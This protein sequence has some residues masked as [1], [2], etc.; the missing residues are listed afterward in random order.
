VR[1]LIEQCSS[2]AKESRE[3]LRI[4]AEKVKEARVA[5]AA[6]LV[7]IGSDIK[8]TGSGSTFSQSGTNTPSIPG[9]STPS[10]SDGEFNNILDPRAKRAIDKRKK[11]KLA[12][13]NSAS[14]LS[15]SSSI[16]SSSIPISGNEFT[17][18]IIEIYEE[19]IRRA[20]EGCVEGEVFKNSFS[21]EARKFLKLDEK[22]LKPCIKFVF[23]NGATYER[24]VGEEGVCKFVYPDKSVYEGH[25]LAGLPNGL[26]MRMFPDGSVY[27]GYFF[28]ELPHGLGKYVLKNKDMLE[29]NFVNGGI[30]G[31]CK[32]T[33]S[34][35]KYVCE[36]DFPYSAKNTNW[37]NRV[38]LSDGSVYEGSFVN[39]QANGQGRH[40]L[41]DGSVY[42]GSFVNGRANGQGKYT[43]PDGSVYEGFFVNE[44][45]IGQGKYTL[46]DGSACEGF[47]LNG[48]IQ[49]QGKYTFPDGNAYEGLLLNG[50]PI[51]QGK[52]TFK[53]GDELIGIFVGGK[54]NGKGGYVFSTGEYYVGEFCYGRILNNTKGVL[55]IDESGIAVCR[56]V[57][58]KVLG[59]GVIEFESEDGWK[60][61]MKVLEDGWKMKVLEDGEVKDKGTAKEET[62]K[63]ETVTPQLPSQNHECPPVSEAKT[64]EK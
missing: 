5:E 46:P 35:S 36:N 2:R 64:E 58:A 63:E 18:K 21:P 30:A 11:L 12:V 27:K 39:G 26:G 17:K 53:N 14:P 16:S 55:W 57:I 56:D 45:A 51:G 20:K 32:Y 29:G 15:E 9:V 48:Q 28:D 50:Q 13:E 1:K 47:W 38:V 22:H 52:R 33:F 61:K 41:P 25:F 4:E 40:T 8:F 42:E 60:R 44:Q 3:D 34:A 43:R 31:L 23:S 37:F 10:C 6:R 59:N 19:K 7:Q 62:V 54:I 24:E 49:G